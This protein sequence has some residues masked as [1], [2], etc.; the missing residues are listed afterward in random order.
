MLTPPNVRLYR[1]SGCDADERRCSSRRKE[2]EP[3]RVFDER[4]PERLSAEPVDGRPRRVEA[5]AQEGR[6]QAACS[7]CRGR[8]KAIG[9]P[10]RSHG[11]AQLRSV[12]RHPK[13]TWPSCFSAADGF[14]I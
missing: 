6:L 10:R 13:A 1:G 7:V 5:G 4:S 2:E 3:P 12:K 9:A 14:R 8:H 11:N